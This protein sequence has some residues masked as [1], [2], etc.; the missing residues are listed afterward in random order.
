M[1]GGPGKLRGTTKPDND[2]VWNGSGMIEGLVVYLKSNIGDWL[3]T[4]DLKNVQ[5]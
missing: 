3:T 2:Y 1:A 4:V 5:T